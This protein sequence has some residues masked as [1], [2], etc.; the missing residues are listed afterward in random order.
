MSITTYFNIN[1]FFGTNTKCKSSFSNLLPSIL[2][3]QIW[4]LVLILMI[5]LSIV[6]LSLE[7][8]LELRQAPEPFWQMLP[9]I[10]EKK[11]VYILENSEPHTALVW[12]EI[13]TLVVLTFEFVARLTTAPDKRHFC[14]GLLNIADLLSIIPIWVMIGLELSHVDFSRKEKG[15]VVFA[16]YFMMLLR[17]LRLFRLFKLV[18]HYKTLKILLMAIKASYKELILL[19]ILLTMGVIIYANLMFFVEVEY[20]N[21]M[22]I[23]EGFWWAIITMTTVGYGDLYPKSALGQ[24]IGSAC[25]ITGILVIALPVPVIA[26]NFHAFYASAQA[27]QR[28]REREEKEIMKEHNLSKNKGKEK[29]SSEK[30]RQ[31]EEQKD[32]VEEAETKFP[33]S[34]TIDNL[35]SKSPET[36]ALTPPDNLPDV[37]YNKGHANYLLDNF[38]DDKWI[39]L[40]LTKCHQA[41]TIQIQK[42]WIRACNRG[43]ALTYIPIWLCV[44]VLMRRSM[45]ICEYILRT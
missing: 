9:N 12:I 34:L 6:V 31:K 7:T 4:S 26:N 2:S 14:K 40:Y 10:T 39:E 21:F 13:V 3:L 15:A 27:V 24:V 36:D 33:E 30:K 44:H 43:H 28:M 20:D 42:W 17:M 8:V 35:I 37:W 11:L 41:T 1:Y 16:Y 18:K 32:K 25:A 45:Y 22:S 19:I 5:V 29:G 38:D 23:P